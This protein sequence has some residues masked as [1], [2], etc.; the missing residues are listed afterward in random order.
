MLIVRPE[1][2][3]GQ[4]KGIQPHSEGALLL[5]NVGLSADLERMPRH[6]FLAS[7][8]NGTSCFFPNRGS[9]DE[10]HSLLLDDTVISGPS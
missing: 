6:T 10:S 3:I 8:P 7:Q 1:K 4:V 2:E 9:G 5:G